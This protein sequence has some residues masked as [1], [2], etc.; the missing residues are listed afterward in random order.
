MHKWSKYSLTSETIGLY[1]EIY[2]N[3]NIWDC[4]AHIG[5]DKDRH[6]ITAAEVLKKMDESRI[7]T[8]VVFP[9]NNPDDNKMF[10]LSNNVVYKAYRKYPK[11]FI[12]FFRLNPHFKWRDEFK[13]CVD[14]GFKGVKLHPR[15]QRFKLTF[16]KV[17]KIYEKAEKEDLV[18]MLHAGFGLQEISEDLSLIAKSFPNLRLIIGHSGFVDL[19]NVI[20]KLT[21]YK[22]VLFDTSACKMFDLFDLIKQV[23]SSKIIFGSDIP[24]YDIDLALESVMDAS[25]MLKKTPNQIRKILGGNLMRWFR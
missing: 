3:L 22:N 21:K 23:D 20:K 1:E 12:P 13:R 8:A 14:L 5:H 24:Y 9:L 25:I 17:M 15:S 7:D 18:V 4:H 11:R 6:K 16:S 2:E 19:D 10:T